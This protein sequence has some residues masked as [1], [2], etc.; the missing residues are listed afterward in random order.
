ML[1]AFAEKH[2]ITY[3]L[4][5]D[6]GSHAIRATGMLNEQI[7]QQQAANGV[8]WRE[9]V[10][11]VAYPGAFLLDAEGRVTE[12]RFYAQYRERETGEAILER[13]FGVRGHAH[14]P[15]ATASGPALTVHAYLDAPTY[16]M[17]QRLW[18]TL[19]LTV[20]PGLHIYGRPIPEGYI[21]LDI[22]VDP[23]AAAVVGEVEGPAPAPFR[24]EGLDEQFVVHAGAV[25]FALP[26]TFLQNTG[27][28]DIAITL[29]YQACS[30]T[31]CLPPQ[32]L[33]LRLTIPAEFHI[34]A[35]R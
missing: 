4:L 31:D 19:D 15:E 9:S 30:D 18:L 28:R 22:S 35:Q 10:R 20:A 32:Q 6:E 33:E 16:R 29:R 13:G 7:E 23:G 2:G 12:K 25:T 5:A 11:G 17:A 1:S 26:I 8:A 34:E 27:E 21:P 3:P 24:I 14:G